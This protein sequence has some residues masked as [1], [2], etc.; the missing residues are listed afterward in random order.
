MTRPVSATEP[1]RRSSIGVPSRHAANWISAKPAAANASATAAAHATGTRR[2]ATAT[3]TAATV[4]TRPSH[5]GGSTVSKKYVA[6]PAP[7]KT[8]NQW[9][10][11]SPSALRA[12]ASAA[13]GRK[14]RRGATTTPSP[15]IA[16]MPRP[17]GAVL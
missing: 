11:R 5:Q 1:S 15:A 6:V 17:I 4:V 10:R 12:S 7:R 13:T 9:T 14:R 16:M 8:G 2:S 3:V